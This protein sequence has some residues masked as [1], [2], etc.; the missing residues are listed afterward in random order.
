[1][2]RKLMLLL[3][4]LFVGISLVTAQTQ[5]ITGVVISEEDGQPVVGASVLVK[6]T[7]Q[8][9]IT[10]VDGN[11][12]LANVPSSAKT[13]QISYIGM[14][15]QEVAIKPH[16][17]ITLKPDAKQLD[18]IIVV[19]YGTAKK[20]A[21]TGSASTI[22]AD[23]LEE[24]IVSNITNA[25]SGQVAG[26][27]TVNANG[28][29]GA[30]AT[31]RIRGIGSMS[32]SNAPLYVVDGVPY[33]GDM[34]SINPQDIESLSV[35]KDAAANSIYGARGANGVI[36]ITTKSAKTEKAKVTFDAKW[37]SNSRMVP[38]YDVIG[39]AEYYETQYKT[40]YNSKIYTGSSKAEAYNYADKTLLDAKNGGLG[41]LVYTVPDGEKLIGN[42]F[43][44]NPNAK[45]GYS[46]GKY[47]YTPD[48]WYDEVFSSNFRQEY[49]VSVSGATDKT[50]YY[51]SA[52]YL[53]DP[54]YI[55][56]SN[57][58]RYNV[59]SNI[60]SQITKWLKAGLNMSYN[61]RS[62]RLQNGRWSS[63]NAG[64]MVQNVFT[65]TSYYRPMSSTWMRDM[66]GNL[67]YDKDGN[68]IMIAY[69]NQQPSLSGVEGA[70]SNPKSSSA[71]ATQGYDIVYQMDYSKSRMIQDQ[72]NMVGY[73]EAKFLKDF[74]FN[75]RIGVDELFQQRQVYLPKEYGESAGAEQGVMG[76]YWENSYA[77]NAQQTLS[78]AH[79]YGKHHVDVLVGHEYDWTGIDK[80][81]YRASMSLFDKWD[82]PANFAWFDGA[83]G[84]TFGSSGYGLD[85]L[86]LEGYFGRLNY[87]FDNKYYLTAS[88]R[89]DGSSKFKD[90]DKRW[91]TFW[92]VGAAWRISAEEWMSNASSWLTDLKI[93][94]DYGVTG[95]QS[96][97][98]YY[99]G[100]QTWS[101][102]GIDRVTP[103]S[104]KP[105]GWSLKQNAYPNDGITW[106]KRKTV[107][108]GLD[109]RLWDRFYGTLDWY[110]TNTVDML[111]AAPTSY[112][113]TG[114]TSQTQNC[115]AIRTRGFEFDLGVDI[116]KTPNTTWSFAVN[117]AHY[118]VKTMEVP[119]YMINMEDA[120]HDQKWWQAGPDNW[121]AIGAAGGGSNMFAYRRWI[122]GDYYNLVAAKYMGVDKETG[123]PLFGALVTEDNHSQ[124]PD[125]NVGDVVATTDHTQA[126]MFDLGDATPDIMGGFSTSFRWKNL[127]FSATFAF[128]IGGLFFSHMYGD[129]VYAAGYVGGRYLSQELVG[130]TFNETN[131]NAK[132]PIY[133]ASPLASSEL[134]YQNGNRVNAGNTYTD[135]TVFDA[136][137]LNVKNITIGYSLPQKWMDKA[138][139]GGIR[140]YA[141]FDN[142]W[143]IARQGIDPRN[144]LTG[145]YDV[146]PMPYPQIRSCSLGVNITF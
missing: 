132:F 61:R 64:A 133:M 67:M 45:L 118:K 63:R 134:T 78:W 81:N 50:D 53:S 96:G 1:M 70:Y 66:D 3:A 87:I 30:S 55:A 59:R 41:Y 23:K 85:R 58:E 139:I 122:G 6:G 99:S 128:Q 37:G 18:E 142:M 86:A 83:N 33:D 89:A 74:T 25:L 22:K 82:A 136:S 114:Q 12:N 76:R 10:D 11:F 4:C 35:L 95:N 39:T 140:V 125:A 27:Q 36:L 47:Y 101:Y 68:K 84:S 49:N 44:L 127:D 5:K 29:P 138:G 54:S 31:V 98:G 2:K 146:G 135:L 119:E 65:W 60:N 46:D 26:I 56:N 144:S 106:E 34:S 88:I 129:Y 105:N 40:L 19:A 8:G 107:D 102:G 51:I 123:L 43:K 117:G 110:Q 141:S 97:I 62:T 116:I 80:M 91:G 113:M 7:T 115:G 121:N 143:L 13:L 109:F 131:T 77:V 94:A 92:S 120:L 126:Y 112:A 24:R 48:D 57:F 93:R 73:V 111:M 38:Q 130:N 9:T 104:Y 69:M 15:A 72:F 124:F 137:Y 75:A 20:S 145:G 100:Y 17:K 71:S 42:N 16:L 79:D 28:A 90:M 108:V 14:Q 103:G 21:F 32:S 52:G